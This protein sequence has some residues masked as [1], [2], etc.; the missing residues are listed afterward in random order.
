MRL[1]WLLKESLETRTLL[2]STKQSPLRDL[3]LKDLK[4]RCCASYMLDFVPMWIL[5]VAQE[6]QTVKAA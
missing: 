4:V 3:L 1:P 5:L 6:T 2:R